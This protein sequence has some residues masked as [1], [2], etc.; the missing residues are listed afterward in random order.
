[1]NTQLMK[2]LHLIFLYPKLVDEVYLQLCKQSTE[3]AN[4][5]SNSLIFSLFALL[6]S[7]FAPSILIFE[8]ILSFLYKKCTQELS[9]EFHSNEIEFCKFAF[10]KILVFFEKGKEF[11]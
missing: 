2:F 6:S 11:H 8:L 5:S 1:M 4:P 9:E 10:R 3:N 7:V